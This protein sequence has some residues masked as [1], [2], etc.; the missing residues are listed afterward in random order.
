MRM[1]NLNLYQILK[2][3]KNL[4]LYYLKNNLMEKQKNMKAELMTPVEKRTTHKW[5]IRIFLQKK[6]VL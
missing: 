2:N 4:L 1:L 5:Q 6:R 3:L